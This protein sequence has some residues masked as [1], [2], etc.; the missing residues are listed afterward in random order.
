VEES[1][2]RRPGRPPR[3]P[4]PV[5]LEIPAQQPVASEAQPPLSPRAIEVRQER[6]RRDSGNTDVM[7]RQRLAIPDDIQE[8]LAAKGLEPRWFLDSP[9]RIKRA[10][11]EDWDFVP[12]MERVSANRDTESEHVLM[13]KRKD[14][15]ADDRR[16][17]AEANQ[18]K[19]Q[20]A[21]QQ[22][23]EKGEV[24][25]FADPDGSHQTEKVYG[26]RHTQNRI[27]LA[28]ARISPRG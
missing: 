28:E 5:A 3:S 18:D 11:A 26:P 6:R 22:R 27:S 1:T 16:H 9:G 10:L 7:A 4:Q 23:D 13:C 25:T 12:G 20:R 8:E 19:Q 17:L 2:P 24:D 21:T 14:W 15:Y